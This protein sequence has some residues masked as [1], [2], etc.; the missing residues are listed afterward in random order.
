MNIQDIDAMLTH[1]GQP[2]ISITIPTAKYAHGRK[3][4]PELIEKTVTKAKRLLMNTAWPKDEVKQLE[5]RLDSLEK[6]A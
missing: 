6:K 1:K 3:Q 5:E 4:N 2:C